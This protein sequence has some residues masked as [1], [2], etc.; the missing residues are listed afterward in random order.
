M[1][2]E[3]F[4]KNNKEEI[5]DIKYPIIKIKS[6]QDDV[7]VYLKDEKITVSIENYF[8]YSLSKIKGL[9]EK[10]Y[11][12]L[13]DE[14]KLLLAK[15]GCLR[16]LSIKDYSIYQMK[17]YLRKTDLSYK[18]KEDLINE[19]VSYGL[20]DDDKYCKNRINYL[21]NSDLSTKQIKMKLKKEGISD[22]L[23]NEYLNNDYS[24]EYK[25]ALSI[26]KKYVRTIHNKSYQATKTAIITKLINS[27]FSYEIS[28]DVVNKIEIQEIDEESLL[29]REYLKAFNKYSKKYDK[30]DL[31][32]KIYAYLMSKGFK[33]EDIKK[34]MSEL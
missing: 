8:K 30:Y 27:G 19:L 18:E 2:V 3:D 33:N 24:I 20:L 32:N 13:K 25:K 28:S 16:K 6:R 12:V 34:V 4:L 1:K 15:K 10:T 21:N 26:A 23:I 11:I 29:N 7:L 22:N 17:E 5:T 9:D 14:E 31:R